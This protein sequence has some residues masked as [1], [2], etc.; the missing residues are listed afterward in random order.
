MVQDLSNLYRHRGLL[1]MWIV[2]DIKVRYKQS[3]L[4]AA[5]A[6]IQP[7]VLMLVF[8]VVFSSLVRVSTGEVPYPVF[9]YTAVL[10][11]TFLVA[12]VTFGVPSLINNLNLVTKI[13]FPREILPIG[14]LGVGLLDLI[15][16]STVFVLLL[17]IY[18]VHVG[19]SA[20]W[21]PVILI[22]QIFL[23]LG[24]TFLGSAA[25]VFYRD[26]RFLVP[27]A[28]QVWFFATPIIY[29]MDIVPENLQPIYM[30]NPM[31]GIINSYR[32]VILYGRP[33]SMT[34]LGLSAAISLVTFVV[35]YRMFKRLEVTFA[36]AI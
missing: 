3:L 26:V 25:T 32:D 17:V 5:W 35:G 12:V 2:R 24:L 21:V 1:W 8:T 33:P 4:G 27:L 31:V 36:D 7:L 20:I 15:I 10:P 14:A 11:W 30:L 16:A 19:I 22:I 28:L 9:S 13:Y 29:P 23:I 18:R 34:Y 6:I